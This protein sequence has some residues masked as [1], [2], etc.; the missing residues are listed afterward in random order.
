M[1]AIRW[2]EQASDDLEAIHRYIARDS[3]HY[4]ATTVERI[5]EA[6]DRLEQFP[7]LGR[8]VPEFARPDLRELLVGRY[9]VVYRLESQSLGLVTILHGAR[10]M[11]LPPGVV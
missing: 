3:A 5:L 8:I 9:R 10:T 7:E 2:S 4:A 1:R 11:R 6:I